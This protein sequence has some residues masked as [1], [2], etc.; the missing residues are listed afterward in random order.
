GG[1]GEGPRPD[2]SSLARTQ[3]SQPRLRAR[4]SLQ[5][6]R[7]RDQMR[8]AAAET[9]EVLVPPLARVA[10]WCSAAGMAAVVALAFGGLV[11]LAQGLYIHAKAMLAQI[12]LER[13]FAQALATGPPAK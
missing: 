2:G 11:L 1:V 8:S 7:A 6:R 4:L 12:M 5:G 13:A 3:L 9:I 10:R